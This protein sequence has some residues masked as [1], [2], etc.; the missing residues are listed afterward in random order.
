MHFGAK[1]K[2]IHLIPT[3]GS[4]NPLN[5]LTTI[6]SSPIVAPY[7]R[8]HHSDRFQMQKKTIKTSNALKEICDVSLVE[9][10][11]NLVYLSGKTV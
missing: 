5:F 2:E 4:K 3:F 11:A 8:K 9:K 1:S 6:V 7:V 10:I